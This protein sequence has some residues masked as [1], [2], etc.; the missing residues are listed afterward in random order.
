MN[1]PLSFALIGMVL[2]V[3]CQNAAISESQ[4]ETRP[5]G[6]TV[7]SRAELRRAL[8]GPVDFGRHVK[9]ILEAKCVACHSEGGLPGRMNLT[10]R[11]AAVKSGALGLFIVPGQPDKSLFVS[12]IG[13]A[14]AH[15]K[16]MPPV[17]EQVTEDEISVLRRWI[18]E[19]ASWPE[20]EAGHLKLEP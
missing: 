12:Q 1:C 8:A 11:A 9:P 13:E 7:L 19:G 6:E 15:L 2:L 17:G 16:A 18:A 20:G 3:G 10:S 4:S 14:P 5:A